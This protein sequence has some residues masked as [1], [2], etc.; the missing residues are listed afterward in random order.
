[1][2]YSDSSSVVSVFEETSSDASDEDESQN[3]VEDMMDRMGDDIFAAEQAFFFFFEDPSGPFQRVFSDQYC[4]NPEV[5][6]DLSAVLEEEEEMEYKN[7]EEEEKTT[8]LDDNKESKTVTNTNLVQDVE[9]S[10]KNNKTTTEMLPS[11]DGDTVVLKPSVATRFLDKYPN[12]SIL[13]PVDLLIN[14]KELREQHIDQFPEIDFI[15]GYID[16]EPTGWALLLSC[17]PDMVSYI[18]KKY[19][20]YRIATEEDRVMFSK[21]KRSGKSGGGGSNP[22]SIPPKPPSITRQLTKR[23]HD[24]QLLANY[25]ESMGGLDKVI[26]IALDVEA[27]VVLRGAVPLPLEIALVP[28]KISEKWK[29][30]HA[31]IHPGEVKDVVTA[32]RLSCGIEK[33]NHC[34]PFRNAVFLR[35]DYTALAREIEWYLKAENVVFVNK[36]SCMDLNAIRWIFGAARLAE[37]SDIRIPDK[38][39]IHCFDIEAV[40]KVLHLYRSE[41]KV[42]EDIISSSLSSSL[43]STVDISSTTTCWYHS[44]LGEV[45]SGGEMESYHIHCALQDAENLCKM[46]RSLILTAGYNEI[47]SS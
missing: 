34:I 26:F 43:L 29:P 1:M 19:P 20:S 27:A 10:T 7:D 21:P 18:K 6:I 4:V 24:V 33:G 40:K 38:E 12:D 46:L 31:F 36:G 30:F 35:N 17:D 2:L 11:L 9:L 14:R 3:V 5:E 37:G 32:C 42:E 15:V 13:I 8:N 47:E 16:S 23:M 44:K 25:I 41:E 45:L 39:E 28:L 22:F